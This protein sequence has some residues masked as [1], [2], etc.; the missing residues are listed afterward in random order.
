MPTFFLHWTLNTAISFQRFVACH[1]FAN[2]TLRCLDPTTVPHANFSTT[3]DGQKG[4]HRQEPKNMR[5]KGRY[6]D[7]LRSCTSEDSG[8]SRGVYWISETVYQC[9]IRP[10]KTQVVR[11]VPSGEYRNILRLTGVVRVYVR[12]WYAVYTLY[13]LDNVLVCF[14]SIG[15]PIN[16]ETS[17]YAPQGT[18]PARRG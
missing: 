8:I 5:P 6:S 11:G 3:G 16:R 10:I 1:D 17:N 4:L 2:K 7:L 15:D 14:E 9:S 13:N 12:N 18:P